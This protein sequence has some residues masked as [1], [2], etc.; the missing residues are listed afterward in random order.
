[1]DVPLGQ[2][3]WIWRRKTL[4][5]HNEVSRLGSV[6]IVSEYYSRVQCT[7]FSDLLSE[8]EGKEGVRVVQVSWV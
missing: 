1:M 2:S 5:P 7:V 4:F 8:G 6:S 3:E